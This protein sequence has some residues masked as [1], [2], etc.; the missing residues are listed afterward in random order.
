[1]NT[2]LTVE[3]FKLFYPSSSLSDE[4][5][6][7][8]CEIVTELIHEL[9]G[10]SLEEGEITETI[11]GNDQNTIYLKKRPVKQIIECGSNKNDKLLSDVSINLYH[12]GITKNVGIFLQGQDIKEPYLASKTT[13]SEIVK[14]KYLAGYK[15]P[16]EVPKILKFALAGL[17]NGMVEDNSEMGSLKSYSRDDVSYTFLDRYERDNK[18]Y[19]IVNRFIS[20]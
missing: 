4:Q 3:E 6:L 15:Y 12:T 11:K 17:I 7:M 9:A 14:I 10:I 2:L 8:Y 19:N 20:C 5:I 1:M 13:K 16:Q 18:F